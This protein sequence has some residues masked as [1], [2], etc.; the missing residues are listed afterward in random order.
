MKNGNVCSKR[1]DISIIIISF[2]TIA[3]TMLLL[4]FAVSII[5]VN[6]YCL[7]YNYKMD[8]YNLNRN[9]IIT[10]NKVEGKYGIYEYNKEKYLNT[11]KELLQKT[12]GLNE[13]LKNGNKGIKEIKILEYDILYTSQRDNITKKNVKNDTIHVVT[14]IEYTPIIFNSI[15]PNNCIFT[16]HNDISIKMYE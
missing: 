14:S 4:L 2:T 5:N 7:V 15:F 3:I 12:Y 10:V 8:L 6:T 1:G 11:F 13:N 16:I 9:A